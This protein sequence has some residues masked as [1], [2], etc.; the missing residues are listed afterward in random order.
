MPPETWTTAGP[1][2]L[3]R[4]VAPIAGDLALLECWT[5]NVI[6]PGPVD[7]RELGVIVTTVRLEPK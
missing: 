7:K 2:V 1:Y 3:A 6:P 5:A 4:D